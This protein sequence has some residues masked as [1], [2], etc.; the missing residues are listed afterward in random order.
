MWQQRPTRTSK[1]VPD[2]LYSIF[3]SLY[4]N[5]PYPGRLLHAAHSYPGAGRCAHAY[6]HPITH[7][8]AD[9][10]ADAYPVCGA[11]GHSNGPTDGYAHV[12]AYRDAGSHADGYSN[13]NT[14]TYANSYGH[15]NADTNPHGHAGSDT[16]SYILA[17]TNTNTHTHSQA[18]AHA[19]TNPYCYA[20]TNTTTDA[21]SSP[22]HSH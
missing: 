6:Q 5:R 22:A 12:C 13:T 3:G 7:P 19:T 2:A 16:D 10:G 9:G 4:S 17:N 21:H 20:N 18:H 11:N 8:R 14:Y 15:T 1:G